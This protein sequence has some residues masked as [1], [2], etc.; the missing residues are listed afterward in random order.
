MLY[1]ALLLAAIL[2]TVELGIKIL[3]RLGVSKS[4]VAGYEGKL[5]R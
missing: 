2:T 1:R 5:T 4:I 3:P